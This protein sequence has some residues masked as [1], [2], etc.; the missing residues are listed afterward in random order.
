[1]FNTI[2]NTFHP[3]FI[4]QSLSQLKKLFKQHIKMPLKARSHVFLTQSSPERK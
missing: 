2:L 4:N 3:Q 1:M